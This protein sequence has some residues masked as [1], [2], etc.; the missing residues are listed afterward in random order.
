MSEIIIT[1]IIAINEGKKEEVDVEI[2]NGRISRIERGGVLSKS[3]Q[4][5][6][7]R[8]AWLL[9]GVI[10][11]QV[12]FREPG[13][14][15]KAEIATESAAAVAGGVTS[16]MEM[17]NT[18]PQ[19]I[20]Q[21]E[22]EKK[23][24]RAS[25]VSPANYSF[26]FGATNKNADEVLALDDDRVCGI[27]IFMGSSTGDMLVDNENTL[28]KVF[29]NSNMLIATHCEDEPTIRRNIELAKEKFHGNIPI[30]QHPIIR[31]REACI[32][33]SQ[34]AMALAKKHNTR[35]HILHITTAQEAM[36]FEAGAIESK[37]IT[38]EACV[39]HLW[40]S[41][42]DYQTLGSKIQCNPAVKTINDREAIWQALKENR[43]D[44]IATDHAPHLLEEKA[45]PYPQSPSGLPLVQHSLNMMM[46]KALEGKA[47]PEWVVEKMSHAPAKCFKVR[48]RG[49]IREGYFADLVLFDPNTSYTVTPQNILYKCAWSP[50]EDFTFRG[51]ILQTFVNGISVFENNKLTGHKPGIAMHF[52]R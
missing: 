46:H 25:Q 2:S 17:P 52:D 10:D 8:G 12:H 27:K 19:T 3:H 5:I 31:S 1:N 9:P 23:F 49:F 48:E 28:E 24:I 29:A 47:S 20:N 14:T 13:F 39:H 41:E 50:L 36:N 15:H 16:F 11:D 33:S 51:R 18:N 32:L 42:E 7:G 44:I 34:K 45:L 4:V 6:D 35:L 26:F 30:T 21:A 22:L 43:I 38:A 40:F 37:R